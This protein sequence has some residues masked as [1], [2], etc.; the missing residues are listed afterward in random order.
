M[1]VRMLANLARMH[2]FPRFCS[3]RYVVTKWFSVL[4]LVDPQVELH[5]FRRPFVLGSGVQVALV[6]ARSRALPQLSEEE[7]GVVAHD[8]FFGFA[9]HRLW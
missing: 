9:A 1:T 8:R 3:R 2:V 4:H 6:G 7:W 5:V